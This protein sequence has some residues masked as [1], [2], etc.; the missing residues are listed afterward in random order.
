ML[1]LGVLTEGGSSLGIS[2]GDLWSQICPFATG[3]KSW[4]K[5]Q[6]TWGGGTNA[7]ARMSGQQREPNVRHTPKNKNTATELKQKDHKIRV[8]LKW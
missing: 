5:F 4:S 7:Y 2:P 6:V 1:T 3:I 8:G